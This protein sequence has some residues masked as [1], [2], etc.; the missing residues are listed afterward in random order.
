MRPAS[1]VALAL[2]LLA[3]LAGVPA[4]AEERAAPQ[5]VATTGL[6][7]TELRQT[8]AAG[9][10]LEP[11]PAPSF[12]AG[13]AEGVVVSV[14]PKRTRQT[15]EGIGGS[16]TES[17]A[18]VLARLPVREKDEILDAFFGPKGA[19]FTITRVP[20][21]ASDFSP[22]GHYSYADLP[23]DTALAKFTIAPDKEGFPGAMQPGYD[24]LPLIQD[25][26]ARQPA[27]KIV[28]S[29]WTAPAWMKD[30]N[31]WHEP[32]KRGG[33]LKREHYPTFARYMVAYLQAYRTEGVAIWAITPENEPLGNGGQWESMELSATDLR[34]YI[35]GHLGPALAKAGLGDVKILSYDQ[36]RDD[37]AIAYADAVLG[38][39]VAA[40]YVWGTALHWYQSTSDVRIPV[41]EKIAERYPTKALMH[42]EGCIDAIGARTNLS[43]EG[44]FL[45]WR[46]DA[47]WWNEGAIDWGF[48]WAPP[49]Q[50]KDHPPY[51]PVDRYARDLIE[52]LN[53]WFTGW[54]DWNIVLD[55][56]GGPNH[57]GNF[58][59]APVMVE[60][61]QR[62]VYFTPL[63]HV[64]SHFSRYLRPGDRIV[65]VATN[66]P[67]LGSDDFHATAALSQDGRQVTVVA[68]NKAAK[69]LRYSVQIGAEHAEIG[70]P[71]HALQTMRIELG[72][73][74]ATAAG[75]A[76]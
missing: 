68:F 59:G 13:L 19:D 70:I 21:G 55:E 42:T 66:A 76:R 60:V 32:G 31:S 8:S 7:L 3:A 15:I 23:G 51:A 72:A 34:D 18:H 6:R 29:P 43:Q 56:R 4:S 33:A 2:P 45:G 5:P 35:A 61:A 50:K 49:E 26:L 39:P 17:S 63:Y 30:N 67:G 24:L 74:A 46:N 53:H 41:I 28:A 57:V 75:P 1:R 27:L 62:R 36:N 9:D 10:K 64:I 47:W 65:E 38:D 69:E 54:I 71:A 44:A 40:P 11:L 25:A 12:V 73:A 52:G 58:A 22:V 20:V 16:L 37:N 48:D 14:D